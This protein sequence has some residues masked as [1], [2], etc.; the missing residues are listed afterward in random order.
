[1]LKTVDVKRQLMTDPLYQGLNYLKML[2]DILEL[3]NK[4]L[5]I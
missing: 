5:K 3:H 1:L 4:N 2:M